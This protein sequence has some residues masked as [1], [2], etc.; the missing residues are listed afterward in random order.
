MIGID[1]WLI[2]EFD[3]VLPNAYFSAANPEKKRVGGS[4][5]HHCSWVGSGEA[6]CPIF[7]SVVGVDVISIL[8]IRVS[9]IM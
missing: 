9:W 1:P 4:F 2:T 6:R 7:P 5:P 8:W 3:I